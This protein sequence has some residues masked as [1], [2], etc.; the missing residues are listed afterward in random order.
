VHFGTPVATV[1]V[2]VD[3]A[4][5]LTATGAAEYCEVW[6][7]WGRYVTGQDRDDALRLAPNVHLYGGF[8]GDENRLGERNWELNETILSGDVAGDDDPGDITVNRSDNLLEVVNG[9]NDAVFDGFTVSGGNRGLASY[10]AAIQ[11]RNS[12]FTGNELA[13]ILSYLSTPTVSSCIFTNDGYGMYV[14]DSS[15]TVTGCTFSNNSMGG[16]RYHPSIGEAWTLSATITNSVFSDNAGSFGGGMDI[17]EIPAVVNGCTFIGNSATGD[18]GGGGLVV[19]DSPSVIA[20]SV[21]IDNSAGALGGGGLLAWG[22]PESG[23]SPLIMN[24]TFVNNSA[25]IGGGLQVSDATVTN[26]IVWGNA[27]AEN[28]QIASSDST[29]THT[30]VQGGCTE[31][32][33]CTDDETGNDASDPLFAADSLRL[34]PGSPCVDSGNTSALPP[35]T[36]DLDGDGDT[37]EPLP[38]DLDGNPRVVGEVDRGA[39]E[40]QPD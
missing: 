34:T 3:L 5:D 24:C 14:E 18:G 27:A 38:I 15:F 4:A 39:Y 20:N 36:A 9:A 28:P 12:V 16:L 25:E 31:A 23:P 8:A 30:T 40:L 37:S 22:Y 2:G 35:D 26:S 17:W 7:G 29:I 32:D 19:T 6:V 10:D 11:V 1:Q 33:G 13:G 21:F